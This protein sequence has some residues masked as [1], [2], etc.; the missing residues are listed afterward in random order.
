MN[1][2]VLSNAEYQAAFERI[3]RLALEYVA[4]VSERPTFPKITGN[5]TEALFAKPLPE[6]GMGSGALDDLGAVMASVRVTGPR[7][8]G[9]VLGSGEPIG[10]AADLL[11]S[12]LNQNVTAWRSSPSTATRRT[13]AATCAA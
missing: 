2:L 12:V 1:P 11:V 4:S 3:S 7:F 6:Q 8:F 9:Y 10:A 5:E 13:P